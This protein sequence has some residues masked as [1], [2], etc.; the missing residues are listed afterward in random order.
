M[1]GAVVEA[2]GAIGAGLPNPVFDLTGGFDSRIVL[3]AALKAGMRPAVTVAG[4]AGDADVEVARHLAGLYGLPLAA[5]SPRWK[6]AAEWRE[7]ALAALAFTDGEYDVLEYARILGI[8]RRLREAGHGASVNGSNGEILKG[9]WWELLFPR[10]GEVEPLNERRIAEARF[11]GSAGASSL[12]AARFE[13]DLAGH[14]AGVIQR[15]NR[16]MAGLPNTAQL[17]NVYLTLRMQRWQGR[18]ASST[19]RLWPST[20]PFFFR[21]PLEAALATPPAERV[22]HRLSRRLIEY[23]DPRLAAQPLAQGYPA[24][25]VRVSTLHRFTP[26]AWEIAGKFWRHGRRRLGLGAGPPPAANA[27][28]ILA[29]DPETAALLE[30]AGMRTAALY[31]AGRLRRFVEA[32]RNPAFGDAAS[33]ARV[34]T[35]EALARAAASG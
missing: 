5:L 24:L 6:D 23:L 35:L 31:D 15:A 11:A 30:P 9:Y 1:A 22:R 34:F 13:T 18:I 28:A 21:G 2:C 29:N 26:L 19:A 33:W 8:H 25:P 32:A 27:V 14:F 4:P 10:T 7:A 3:G 12:L 17:D 20:S 16:E